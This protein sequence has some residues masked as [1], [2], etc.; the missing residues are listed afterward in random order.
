MAGFLYYSPNPAITSLETIRAA[1]FGYA[2]DAQPTAAPLL[3]A[4]PDGN[5]GVILADSRRVPPAQV[6]YYRDKQAWRQI[7]GSEGSIQRS[8]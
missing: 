4:G 2:F 3:G 8:K 5:A 6:G 1:G 7:P